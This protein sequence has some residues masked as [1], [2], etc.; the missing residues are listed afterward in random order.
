[1]PDTRHKQIETTKGRLSRRRMAIAAVFFAAF[2]SSTLLHQKFYRIRIQRIQSEIDQRRYRDAL[3]LITSLE[4]IPFSGSTLLSYLKGECHLMTGRTD[5]AIEIWNSIRHNP[6][7]FQKSILKLG[8]MLENQGRLADAEYQYRQAMDGENREAIDIRHSLIQLLWLE[9]RLAEASEL[10]E[11][12]WHSNFRDLGP[13][14]GSTL[15]NLRAHLSLDFEV[16]PID[17]VRKR[18][19]AISRKQPDDLGVRLAMVNL[20]LRNGEYDQASQLFSKIEAAG[21]PELQQAISRTGLAIDQQKSAKLN[22]SDDK[23]KFISLDR[24]TAI[25][26]IA[27]NLGTQSGS[28]SLQ[29]LL[30]DCLLLHPSNIETIENLSESLIASGNREKAAQ[31]RNS[32]QSLDQTR[33]DYANLVGSDLRINPEKMAAMAASLGRWFEA[34]AFSTMMHDQNPGPDSALRPRQTYQD[35]A[36]ISSIKVT[37]PALLSESGLATNTQY[38]ASPAANSQNLPGIPTFIDT[39][40]SAGIAFSF[41]SGRTSQR[42]LPETMSGGLASID[43][44]RDG[45]LDILL[46]QGGHFPHKPAQATPGSGDRLYRNLGTGRFSDVTTQAGLP[47]KSIGYSHGVTVGDINNDSFDDILVTRFGSYQLLINSGNGTFD[48]Q[49][50]RWGLA[51]NRD[52]PTSAAFTDFDNDGDLDL[53]VCHYVV[54]D[55]D[56]PR[57]C[58]NESGGQ[59]QYCV[60][61]LLSARPDHLFRND[62]N[63]FT[64]VSVS[65]G[66]TANDTDGRGLGVVTADFNRD[67]L[68]DIFVANDG[69]ANFLYINRGNLQFTNEAFSSGVAANSDGGFQ[70]G[71]GVSCGDFNGDLLPDIVVTNFY[72][73]STSYF[74][75]LG[76]GLFRERSGTTG[77]KEATRY[78]LGFGTSLADFNNDGQ[79]DLLTANG[80]VNDVRPVIPYQMPP[81]LFLG[82]AGRSFFDTGTR[83]GTVFQTNLI[84]RG[85]VVADF[86]NDGLLDAAQ[87]N[88]DDSFLLMR[89]SGMLNQ[90]ANNFLILKLAGIKS[91]RNAIGAEVTCKI[92]PLK[93]RLFRYGGGS[94][95]SSADLRLH[96]GLN[97]AKIVDEIEI[98]WPDGQIAK[99][100]NI[101]ANNAFEI[102]QGHDNIKALPGFKT[103]ST[104]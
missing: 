2:I 6:I 60:P 26:L 48:D 24:P 17:H 89:N 16:Y 41:Q 19:E 15:A 104:P 92:G 43:Y 31:L 70:A 67:G 42:Q 80:H 22:L 87:T 97:S 23:Y 91:N 63:S 84:G 93:K 79:L 33:R 58:G 74:E 11:T 85:L 77:L 55:P 12:N 1:M 4:S 86:D 10:V 7:L 69:T 102:S 14:D 75:N 3:G 54:W 99:F 59:I 52:W 94:Y 38:T 29:Q 101:P 50:A 46:L 27:R 64:D 9:G 100:N 81:Q 49:T 37:I 68:M 66:I 78:R 73:E 44:D 53:Y 76:E 18:L 13:L 47:D 21:F 39:T 28:A 45:L 88:L 34:F 5:I 25:N 57:L 8:E 103:L 71:M 82:T 32:R 36:R 72:G 20:M 51:G 96:L 95:Q 90:P 56:N 62:G 98:R 40:A 83:S 30:A 35:L 61:H 65:S